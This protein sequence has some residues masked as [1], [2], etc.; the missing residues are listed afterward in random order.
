MFLWNFDFQE[1]TRIKGLKYKQLV[2]FEGFVKDDSSPILDRIILLFNDDHNLI[3]IVHSRKLTLPKFTTYNLTKGFGFTAIANLDN[4]EI[5][6]IS[7][8]CN[9][10]LD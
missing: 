5:E 6:Q 9:I 1:S 10:Y 4:K 2:M 3:G 7:Q 8:K